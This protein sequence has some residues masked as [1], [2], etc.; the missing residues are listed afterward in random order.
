[1]TIRHRRARVS[2]V[3][4][5]CGQYQRGDDVDVAARGVGRLAARVGACNRRRDDKNS[6]PASIAPAGAAVR[7][8]CAI[9]LP[10]QDGKSPDQRQ[11]HDDAE[12]MYPT[13]R[14]EGAA[15]E[16]K[17]IS[18]D[19]WSV[20]RGDAGC[21]MTVQK[22]CIATRGTTWIAVGRQPRRA[23]T[24]S[25]TT[26]TIVNPTPEHINASHRPPGPANRVIDR[27]VV[28]GE[29]QVHETERV[30]TQKGH[31]EG[32]EDVLPTRSEE[33]KDC[34]RAGCEPWPD[35]HAAHHDPQESRDHEM[36]RDRHQ[37]VGPVRV[38]PNTDHIARYTRIGSVDQ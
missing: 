26:T 20:R 35:T 23:S 30:L 18:D 14:R 2:A 16:R 37:H 15:N 17:D 21:T 1:M 25:P 19:V 7:Q 10:A 9:A 32:L 12:H 36:H 8:G 6:A 38:R 31:L 33:H 11:R 13:Q 28:I 34:G 5:E 22:N 24:A 3:S 27:A 4:A 29:Q